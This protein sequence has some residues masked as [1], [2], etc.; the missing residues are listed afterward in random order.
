MIPLLVVTITATW[1]A[2]ALGAL[3]VLAL[4]RAVRYEAILV[5]VLVAYGVDEETRSE[6]LD[7]QR[8]I[9]FRT[10]RNL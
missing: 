4:R 2:F 3:Y 7:G 9:T 10:E 6:I 5:A 8:T 1:T